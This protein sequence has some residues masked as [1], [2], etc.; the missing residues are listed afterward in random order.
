MTS[1]ETRVGLFTLLGAAVFAGGILML[2]DVELRHY[3][4]LKVYFDSAEGLPD[5]GPVKIAGV[6]VGKVDKIM[7]DGGRAK[8]TLRLDEKVRVHRGARA[9]VASTGMIG[10]KYL[11]LTQGNPNA[12]LMEDGDS[13]QGDPSFSFDDAMNE[14]RELFREENGEGS[15]AHNL[16][17]TLAN[18]RRIT[19]ALN[20]SVKDINAFA[21][22]ARVVSAD[23][24]EITTARKEDIEVALAKFRA[25]S[26]KLDDLLGRIQRGEGTVGKLMSDEAMGTE[27]KQ[28][29]SSLK[30]TSQDVQSVMKR[31]VGIKVY[32]DYRQRYDFEDDQARAD[33]G[34]RIVPRPGKFYYLAG[35]NVGDREDRDVYGND[36][37]KKNTFTGVLGKDF[38][39]FTLYG[40]VIRSAGGAGVRFRPLFMS[41]KWD[42][43]LEFEGEAYDFGRDDV[44]QGH[45]LDKPVYNA[46]LRANIIQP[47]L[48]AGAAVEDMAVRKNV[49]AHVNLTFGDE[50]I[51]YLLGFVGLAR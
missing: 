51:A 8:V 12:P 33:V 41:K 49:N 1:I 14:L 29:V 45:V 9:Q 24:R 17:V 4:R 27:L 15:P 32:W 36:I 28:T 35:N 42:R 40:G 13:I 19:D 5:K 47:W 18:L 38:G 26:E 43:R 31:I 30:Q 34:L 37:E 25:V 46:G 10:S 22:N 7:L 2:G 23:L 44:V 6:E 50:D 20:A 39:P 11:D 48:W 21:E 3:Y 16:K